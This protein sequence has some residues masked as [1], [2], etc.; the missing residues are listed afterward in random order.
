[1]SNV[2]DLSPPGFAAVIAPVVD[3]VF[4]ATM[5]AGRGRGGADISQRYGGPP[6]I[7]FLIDFRTRL[8]WPG[9][10]VSRTQFE[11][12]TRYRDQAECWRVIDEQVAHGMLEL[13]PDGQI[14]AT[15]RGRAFLV[16][17]YALHARVTEE[18]WAD[19]QPRVVRL[20]PLLSSALCAAV[21]TAGEALRAMAPPYE[22]AGAG[23][24]VLVFN[25]LGTLRYHRADAHAAAWVVAGLTAAQIVAL[26]TGSRRDA[27]EA[28]TDRRAAPPFAVLT[29]AQRRDLLTDLAALADIAALPA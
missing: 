9:G 14:S 5:A 11:A 8:A 28:D 16:E 25:R 7:G 29:A 18:L 4:R 2:T 6:A 17:I 10:E 27:I 21:Q 1:M 3:R 24:G 12:L 19:H 20:A 26:P 23:A 13:G 22:P 15:D